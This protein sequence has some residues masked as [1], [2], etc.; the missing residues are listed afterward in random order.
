MNGPDIFNL[1]AAIVGV[2]AFLYAVIEK[3]LPST[4]LASLEKSFRRADSLLHEC[5]EEGVSYSR[6][7]AEG[8]VLAARTHQAATLP[9]QI[10][11]MCKGLSWHTYILQGK[12]RALIAYVASQKLIVAQRNITS[13]SYSSSLLATPVRTDDLHSARSDTVELR[14]T[15]AKV[16]GAEAQSPSQLPIPRKTRARRESQTASPRHRTSSLL[17]YNSNAG[18]PSIS[19]STSQIP[20]LSFSRRHYSSSST[21]VPS[22]PSNNTGRTPPQPMVARPMYSG[23]VSSLRFMVPPM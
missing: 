6:L 15:H 10:L 20:R 17:P 12:V 11:E 13:Q 8:D 22:T 23:A 14:P 19:S 7:K 21:S 16:S 4:R 3:A 18:V 5:S 2:M 1:I 9:Q